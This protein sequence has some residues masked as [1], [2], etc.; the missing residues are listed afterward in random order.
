MML[1]C[2]CDKE[3]NLGAGGKQQSGLWIGVCI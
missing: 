3:V 1:Q 2:K